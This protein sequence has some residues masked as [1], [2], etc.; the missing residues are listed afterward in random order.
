MKYRFMSGCVIVTGPPRAIC[1]RKRGIT[2][3]A[4]PSTFPNRTA[5]YRVANRRP[6]PSGPAKLTST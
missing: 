1:S 5:T 3:P 6:S 4:D 2:D